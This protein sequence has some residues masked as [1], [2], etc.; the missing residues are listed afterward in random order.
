MGLAAPGVDVWVP[1]PAAAVPGAAA[2]PGQ[3]V[4][5]TSFASALVSATL[6]RAGAAWWQLPKPTQLASLCQTATDLGSP[7]RDAV[8]GCGLLSLGTLAG[9][10]AMR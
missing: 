4:S 7:G 6:A 8:Y 1:V 5:G 10:G 3:Y 2:M 9:A